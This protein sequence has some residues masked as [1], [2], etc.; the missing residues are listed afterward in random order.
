MQIQFFFYPSNNEESKDAVK[1][2]MIRKVKFAHLF[3]IY[4]SNVY[5]MLTP[6]PGAKDKMVTITLLPRSLMWECAYK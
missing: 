3:N 2:D 5:S 1:T 4:L 6:F